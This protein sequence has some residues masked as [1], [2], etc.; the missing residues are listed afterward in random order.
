MSGPAFTRAIV[1]A[2]VIVLMCYVVYTP[3]K[4]CGWI[5]IPSGPAWACTDGPYESPPGKVVLQRHSEKM[6]LQ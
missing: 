6:A 2:G 1:A 3:H 4:P 5:E